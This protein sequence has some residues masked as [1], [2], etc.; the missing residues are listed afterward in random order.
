MKTAVNVH[1]IPTEGISFLVKGQILANV[2]DTDIPNTGNIQ[3]YHLYFTLLKS[4]LEISKIKEGDWITDGNKIFQAPDIDGFIGFEKI[5]A[6]TDVS[7]QCAVDKSPYP[8]EIYGLPQIPQSFIQHFVEQYNEGNVIEAVEIEL[9]EYEIGS[10]GLSNGEPTVDVRLKLTSNF[11]DLD[12]FELPRKNEVCIVPNNKMYSRDEVIEL[13]NKAFQVGHERGFSGYP[14]TENWNK[15][16]FN[17]WIE[18]NLK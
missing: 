6:T 4:N 10:Y 13:C 8:M 3:K 16:T 11:A 12:D 14:N 18:E 9:E 1:L 2:G 17:Q 7:L 5:V 15:P